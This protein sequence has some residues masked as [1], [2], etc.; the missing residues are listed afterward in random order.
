MEITDIISFFIFFFVPTFVFHGIQYHKMDTAVIK[1]IIIRPVQSFE[2][3]GLI[4]VIRHQEVHIV[5]THYVIN[6]NAY[7]S[8]HWDHFIE[9][10]E[11][12][13]H[14]VTQCQVKPG[15]CAQHFC[16]YIIPVKVHFFP[17]F[18]LGVPH[19]N[20]FEGFFH[21]CFDQGKMKQM[22]QFSC[23]GNARVFQT[24]GGT[25][26]LMNI[27]KLREVVF[28]QGHLVIRGFSDKNNGFVTHWQSKVPVL[29]GFHHLQLVG[30]KNVGNAF[31]S[32]IKDTAAIGILEYDSF[33]GFFN[34]LQGR[35]TGSKKNNKQ[36]IKN[37]KFHILHLVF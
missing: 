19:H 1:R 5:V 23:R 6:R 10:A 18:S 28:V 12:I 35:K 3:F 24:G 2:S 30:N 26:G 37:F 22:G 14:N 32:I 11:V 34:R 36:Q 33:N 25:L 31:F 27:V 21:V 20:D 4:F 15:L 9:N 7:L 29:I 17:G 16:H 8:H 13:V